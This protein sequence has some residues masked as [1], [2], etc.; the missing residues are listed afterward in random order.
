MSTAVNEKVALITGGASGVGLE[1]V[2][3]LLRNGIKG[4]EVADINTVY[5]QNA[6]E[7]IEKEFGMNRVDFIQT[8]VCDK[9]QLK[10][11][12]ERTIKVYNQLDMVFSNAG[13]ADDLDFQKEVDANCAEVQCKFLIKYFSYSNMSSVVQGKVALITGSAGGIGF[14]F[15][16]ELLRNG[17]KAVELVDVNADL[18]QKAKEQIAK[19]FGPDKVDFTKADVTDKNQLE[20]AF[21]K[22]IQVFN[23][24]D[25]VINNAGILDDVN[26]EK[27]IQ[28]NCN[29]VVYGT[30]LAVN[31]YLP[32]YRSG[33]EGYVVN[34]SSICALHPA[35]F[36]PIYTGSK[37]FVVGFGRAIGASDYYEKTKVKVLTLCPGATKTNI[38]LKGLDPE[39]TRIR[40]KD[41]EAAPVQE[42]SHMGKELVNI[43]NTATSG[44]VWLI[45]NKEPAREITY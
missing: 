45:E 7:E 6:K 16:Q 17:A 2:K 44:T 15:A 37:W 12:F 33:K 36:A 19:E 10:A 29:G 30:L 4:I 21:K 27:E 26:Y 1:F 5:I 20:A 25:I 28:I 43:L 11:A 8:D 24:L 22:A 42:A 39:L 13:I 38:V 18:L 32:K 9:N 41:I 35:S 34:L 14:A 40:L 31:E 23:Q 3:E